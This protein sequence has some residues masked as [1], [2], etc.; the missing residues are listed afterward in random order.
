MRGLRRRR[1]EA[2]LLLGAAAVAALMCA[3]Y[4]SHVLGTVEDWTMDKRFAIRGA[5]TPGDVAIVA[6]D[7]KTLAELGQWPFPRRYHG[8]VIRQVADDHPRVIAVDIQFTEPTNKRDDSA[9]MQAVAYADKD[10]A[11]AARGGFVVLGTN[12]TRKSGGNNVFGG[13]AGSLGAAVGVTGFRPDAGGVLRRLPWG[14]RNTWHDGSP[15]TPVESL[16]LV[17]AQ[18]ATNRQILPSRV[19]D[20][21]TI[22]YVGPPGTIPAYSYADV[23]RHRVPADAFEGKVVVIGP[24]APLLGDAHTTPYGA[25][26][27][28]SGAEIQA[29]AIE[30]ALHDFPLRPYRT[31]ALLLIVL[32]SFLVPV[33][34]LFLRWRWCI[35]TAGAAA[36]LYLVAAQLSFN[37][38]VL[39]P[40]AWPVLALALGTLA[41]G[42][43]RPP[44]P[45][46]PACA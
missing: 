17:A 44:R 37:H 3:A 33:A 21:T 1:R 38:G 16:S 15:A 46:R 10:V 19:G 23:L 43:L 39:L 35:L 4:L 6:I 18:I 20:S 29:N 12:E 25:A 40:V 24:S 11:T 28:M 8:S 41:A 36:M 22:A 34:S 45:M 26:T 32:F 9:L 30:T 42:F 31:R 27:P 14:S 13:T 5:H 7:E 2:G